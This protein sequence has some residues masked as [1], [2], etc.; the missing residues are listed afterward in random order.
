MI[1][2]LLITHGEFAAG[3][4]NCAELLLG[5]MDSVETVSL[6]LGED[7]R[8]FRER[9]ENALVKL[10]K[11]AG[12][13]VLTDVVG[14]SP[15][16]TVASYMKQYHIECVTGL[17]LPMLVEAYTCRNEMK[18]EDLVEDCMSEAVQGIVNVKERLKL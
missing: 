7:I 5:S 16:N 1:G 8:E 12:I 3:I 9:V 18:L 14:G 4:K 11:G 13:L 10:D 15:Y 6:R 17:N 2:I